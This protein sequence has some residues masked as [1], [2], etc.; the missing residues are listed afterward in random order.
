MNKEAISEN[1]TCKGLQMLAQ[2]MGIEL[3]EEERKLSKAALVDFI[4]ER[5]PISEM[6]HVVNLFTESA[7]SPGPAKP[8]RAASVELTEC[9]KMRESELEDLHEK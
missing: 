4:A 6:P 8:E 5:A 3:A 7:H 2:S 1:Y 9:S